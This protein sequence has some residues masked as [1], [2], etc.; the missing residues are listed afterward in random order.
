LVSAMAHDQLLCSDLIAGRRYAY[1][2]AAAEDGDWSAA[3][4]IFEQALERAPLLCGGTGRAPRGVGKAIRAACPWLATRRG[5]RPEDEDGSRKGKILS[6]RPLPESEGNLDNRA[7]QKT[8]ARHGR[9]W[10]QGG[11]ARRNW[12]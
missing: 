6:R 10:R 12:S 9:A 4:E 7:G 8:K 11:Q 3:A 1:A 2:K 5:I